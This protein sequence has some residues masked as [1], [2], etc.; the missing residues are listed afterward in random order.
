MRSGDSDFSRSRAQTRTVRVAL[1]PTDDARHLLCCSGNIEI[2]W[3]AGAIESFQ[4]AI[5]V[6]ADELPRLRG[7]AKKGGIA[8]QIGVALRGIS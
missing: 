1:H 5:L 4:N 2:R 8:A 6:M 3:L 7:D